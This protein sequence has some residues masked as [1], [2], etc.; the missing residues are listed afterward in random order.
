MSKRI[1]KHVKSRVPAGQY[2]SQHI[3]LCHAQV[4][5]DLMP[6]REQDCRG[7]YELVA[8]LAQLDGFFSLKVRMY[9]FVYLPSGVLISLVVYFFV[10]CCAHLLATV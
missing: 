5:K 8:K 6:G 2:I 4:A 7:M 10:V 1:L 9:V 3:S